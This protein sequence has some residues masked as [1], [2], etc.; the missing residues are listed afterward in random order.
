MKLKNILQNMNA[1]NKNNKKL[2]LKFKKIKIF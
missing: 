1:K 2:I